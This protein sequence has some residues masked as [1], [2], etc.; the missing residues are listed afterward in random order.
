MKHSGEKENQYTG[1]L[2]LGVWRGKDE[3]RMNDKCA[4]AVV[5]AEEIK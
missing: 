3:L 2:L 4:R 5:A 1:M